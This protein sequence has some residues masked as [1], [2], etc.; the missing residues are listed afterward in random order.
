M[1][2]ISWFIEYCTESEKQN[3]CLST[4]WLF[5]LVI[6]WLTGSCVSRCP[7]PRERLHIASLGKDQNSKFK[8]WFLLNVY[9]FPPIIKSKSINQTIVSQGPPVHYDYVEAK[10]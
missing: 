2:N 10:N 7:A 9:P 1:L 4:E 3:G 8:V 6:M 5:T